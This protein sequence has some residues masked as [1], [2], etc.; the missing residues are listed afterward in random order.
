MDAKSGLLK[1]LG[2]FLGVVLLVLVGV[3]LV[4]A[5][6]GWRMDW[7]TLLDYCQGLQFAGLLVIGIGLLG[8][9]GNWE[10]T[11]S[12]GYQYSMSTTQQSS[13]QRTQQILSDFVQSYT[14][15]LV[16]F[17]AGGLSLLIGWLL[18]SNL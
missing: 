17:I 16:M 4:V 1:V 5:F 3:A 10:V 12:F 11:R 8:I 14:F 9:R 15:M 6:I 7:E 18:E 2:R 13:T